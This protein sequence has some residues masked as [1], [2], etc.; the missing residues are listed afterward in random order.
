M[1]CVYG[2]IVICWTTCLVNV[3][4]TCILRLCLAWSAVSLGELGTALELAEAS[5]SELKWRQLGELA[6]ST[7]KLQV[8]LSLGYST[9]SSLDMLLSNVCSSR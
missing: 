7:G 4:S 5:G 1:S 6:L 8:G 2:R 9:P 3:Q